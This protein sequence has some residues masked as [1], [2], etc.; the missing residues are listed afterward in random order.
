MAGLDPAIDVLA[1]E[2]KMRLPGPGR[3][4][5]FI[6]HYRPRLISHRARCLPEAGWEP[7]TAA[8]RVP[9]ADNIP[10]TQPMV[11]LA[12]EAMAASR[13]RWAIFA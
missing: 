6:G 10:R 1:C 7:T 13:S 8:S 3:G 2:V 9:I 4:M 5:T 11:A 12:E